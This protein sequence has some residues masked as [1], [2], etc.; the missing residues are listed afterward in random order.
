MFNLANSSI[1]S[2]ATGESCWN[3]TRKM[4]DGL[5]KNLEYPKRKDSAS[6]GS[7]GRDFLV[8]ERGLT[9]SVFQGRSFMVGNS[10]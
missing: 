3:R 5:A 8:Q 4:P 7:V 9:S 6:F 10:V 1:S 2:R